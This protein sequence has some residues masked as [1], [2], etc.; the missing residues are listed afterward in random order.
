VIHIDQHADTKENKNIFSPMCLP[1]QREVAKPEGFLKE[2][3]K[4]IKSFV[5]E[6][7]NVGNF[8]TA[9]LNN[10]IIDE[11][12]QIRSEHALHN[13]EALDFHNYNYILD[14]DIDF[15]EQKTDK[16]IKSDFEIIKK[17]LDKVCL[18]TIATSP[19]FMDQKKAIE[20][21]KKIVK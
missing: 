2:N 20:I 21:I 19:Y 5:N 3:D 15:R 12:L 8:I 9:G 13:M 4:S 18:I 1:L 16:E 14:I 7:T 11:V 17:L 10:K 6:K